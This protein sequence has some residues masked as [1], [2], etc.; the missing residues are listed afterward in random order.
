MYKYNIYS[1]LRAKDNS[2]KYLLVPKYEYIYGN[3][4]GEEIH[5]YKTK[6][7]KETNKIIFNIFCDNCQLIVNVMKLIIILTLSQIKNLF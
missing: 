6:I 3:L 1:S 2:M 5:Y 4:K 7:S